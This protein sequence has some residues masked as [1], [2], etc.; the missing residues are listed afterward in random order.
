MSQRRPLIAGN[1][2]MNLNAAQARALV[3]EIGAAS[4]V[5]CDVLVC[6]SYTLI[7]SVVGQ[8]VAVGA[9]DIFWMPSGAFTSR[10]SASMLVDA[11][12]EYVIIGHSETRGRFGKLEVASRTVGYFAETDETCNL[13]MR[14]AIAAGIKP[15][16]C[17]GETLEEREQ[18]RT[19]AVIAEQLRVGLDGVD[20]ATVIIAYEPVWA[21]GTGQTCD[22]PEAERVCAMVRAE[23]GSAGEHVRVLYGG[24]M[25]ASNAPE[26]LC[27]PNIDGGLVGGASLVADEFLAIVAAAV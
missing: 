16:L 10:V 24:S 18:G 17:V 21:I 20:M 3:G 8:G 13:K 27:Q 22:T 12:C 23:L 15:I 5:H 25:K 19:D 14:A 26:L 9:Q 1:W 6:P 2:K 11:G 7:G 4:S